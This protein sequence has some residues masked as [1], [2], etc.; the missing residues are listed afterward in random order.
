MGVR[1]A[2]ARKTKLVDPWQPMGLVTAG[3][4]ER[5]LCRISRG[6]AQLQYAGRPISMGTLNLYVPYRGSIFVSPSLMAHYVDAHEY[7][8]PEI[9]QIAVLECPPMRSIEYLRA[10]LKN[11]PPGFAGPGAT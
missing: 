1:M 3:F 11:G 4:H 2:K 5:D 8:P 6:R 9:Y 10:I 7:A